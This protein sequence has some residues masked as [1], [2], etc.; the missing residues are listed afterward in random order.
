MNAIRNERG[1]ALVLVLILSLVGLAMVAALLFMVTQSTSM[2]GYHRLY[3]TAEDAGLGGTSIAAE[4]I[5]STIPLAAQTIEINATSLPLLASTN[6]GAVLNARYATQLAGGKIPCVIQKLTLSTE[7]W[8]NC[9]ATDATGNLDKSLDPTKEP[10][11][12]F[13][14]GNYTVYAKIVDTVPGNTDSGGLKPGALRGTGVV[15]SQG[16]ISPA[17]NPSLYRIEVQAQGT[18]NAREVSR[19]SVLY[20]Y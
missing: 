9:D 12:H 3:R 8:S 17:A 13:D 6:M 14:L 4:Y 18:S 1:V 5:N 2:S 16:R 7:D 11:I 19:Y 10:D 15:D 20:A